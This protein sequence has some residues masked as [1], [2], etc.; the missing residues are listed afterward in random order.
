MTAQQKF[1]Y[2][3][4]G[5]AQTNPYVL[6][7]FKFDEQRIADNDMRASR[8]LKNELNTHDSLINE[9]AAR[10]QYYIFNHL[11]T[12]LL[13][14]YLERVRNLVKF[15]NAKCNIKVAPDVEMLEDLI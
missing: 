14:L 12:E 2:K 13:N 7:Y 11:F 5:Q 15:V 9:F 4:V 3:K 6:Q 10:T 1:N 8:L